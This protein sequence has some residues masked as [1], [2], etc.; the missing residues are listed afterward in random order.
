MA[1][2]EIASFEA[3][4]MQV[5]VVAFLLIFHLVLPQFFLRIDGNFSGTEL[6]T[7]SLGNTM[8]F[9]RSRTKSLRFI[10]VFR[11]LSK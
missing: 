5:I 9:A 10:E 7:I 11:E 6:R 8:L 3:L 4:S 1:I 2:A